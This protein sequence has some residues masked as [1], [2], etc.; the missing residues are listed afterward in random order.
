MHRALRPLF[1]WKRS[2]PHAFLPPSRVEGPSLLGASQG[3][4]Q[5]ASQ[6]RRRPGASQGAA[7]EL[8]KEFPRLF[9]SFP[10]SFSS[11]F[12]RSFPRI[13]PRAHQ[14]KGEWDIPRCFPKASQELP[15]SFQKLPGSFRN[16]SKRFSR[17][18]PEAAK[19]LAMSFL[20]IPRTPDYHQL[21]PKSFRACPSSFPG[22]SRERAPPPVEPNRATCIPPPPVEPNPATWLAACPNRHG[23]MSFTHQAMSLSTLT[24]LLRHRSHARRRLYRHGHVVIDVVRHGLQFVATCP[25][26][27]IDVVPG[28]Y[29]VVTDIL[30]CL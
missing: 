11:S 6:S 30:Q 26:V 21:L 1:L 18:F 25:N 24:C 3:V 13:R 14:D 16:I 9:T 20:D 4:P 12:P 28:G 10:R 29:D 8:P 23:T 17:S 15:K 2:L 7:Q 22:A 5:E 19:E 27:C